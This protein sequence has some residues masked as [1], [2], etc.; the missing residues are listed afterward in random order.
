MA[1]LQTSTPLM[2]TKG[3][4][5]EIEEEEEND[6]SEEEQVPLKK[7]GKVTIT[8]APNSSTTVFIGRIRG[9]VGKHSG[10]VVFKRPPPTFEENIKNLREGS[11]M[12]NFKSLKYEIRT[13]TEQKHIED[14][15]IQKMGQW[16]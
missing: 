15:V 12:E 14:A 7:K 6:E 9:K 4:G 13:E 3:K 2:L 10:D 11:R 16:K 1:K 8:K 5:E